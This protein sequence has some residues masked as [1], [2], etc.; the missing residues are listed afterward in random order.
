MCNYIPQCISDE[1]A[2]VV[3]YV[4]R[5]EMSRS[6]ET[7]PEISPLHPGTLDPE[8]QEEGEITDDRQH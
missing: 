2:L 4:M 1:N 3:K 5:Q 8:D 7:T 6:R